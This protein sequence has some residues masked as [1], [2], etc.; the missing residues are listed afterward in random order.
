MHER[1]NKDYDSF[2]E[3]YADPLPSVPLT[4]TLLAY[5]EKLPKQLDGGACIRVIDAAAHGDVLRAVYRTFFKREDAKK[6]CVLLVG[7][8]S[9]G[10]SSVVRLLE[11]IFSCEPIVWQRAMIT[12][13]GRNKNWPT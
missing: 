8:H 13:S 6:W 7:A 12:T 5:L 3:L 9:S 1:I 11:E 10:K 2:M 4:E